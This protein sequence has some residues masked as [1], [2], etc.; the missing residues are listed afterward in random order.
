MKFWNNFKLMIKDYGAVEGKAAPV[1][2]KDMTHEEEI[3][4]LSELNKFEINNFEDCYDHLISAHNSFLKA[5]DEC[6]FRTISKLGNEISCCNHDEMDLEINPS[7]VCNMRDCPI[8][9]D[10]FTRGKQ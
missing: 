2:F 5:S 9:L 6:A 7:Y 3:E 8:I 10:L 4:F 1:N